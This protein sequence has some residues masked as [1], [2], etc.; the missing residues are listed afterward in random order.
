MIFKLSWRSVRSKYYHYIVYLIGMVFAATIYYSFSAITYDRVLIDSVGQE[1]SLKNAM[2]IGSLLIIVMIA[3]FMIT[4]NRFFF[5]QRTKEIGI[6]QLTGMKNRQIAS[7]LLTE[8]YILGAAALIAGLILGIIFSKL[9]SMILVK[10]MY[11]NVE[12]ILRISVPS[13]METTG[14]FI[15][16]LLIVSI[17]ICFLVYSYQLTSFFKKEERVGI[18]SEKLTKK[19]LVLGITGIGLIVFSYILSFNIWSLPTNSAQLIRL[20]SAPFLLVGLCT[21]GTY[22]IFK[23]T[24][25]IL[26]QFFSSRK[27]Y[28]SNGL[29]MLSAGNTRLHLSK[30]SNTLTAVSIF[31]ACALGIIGGAASFYTLGMESVNSSDPVDFIVSSELFQAAEENAAEQ[32]AALQETRLNFKMTGARYRY[33]YSISRKETLDYE[34]P[35]N[36]ISLSNYQDYQEINPYLQ[37]VALRSENEAV[38]LNGIQNTFSRFIEYDSAVQ[39]ASGRTIMIAGMVSDYLGNSMLRYNK[40]TMVVSDEVYEAIPADVIFELSAFNLEQRE[41]EILPD[42]IMAGIS[43][44]WQHPVYYGTNANDEVYVSQEPIQASKTESVEVNEQEGWRLNYTSRIAAFIHNR[45]ALGVFIYV[46]LFLGVLALIITGSVLMVRQFAEAEREKAT[47]SLLRKLGISEKQL[48]RLIYRQNI[49]VFLLPIL[50]GLLHAGFA[51]RLYSQLVPS[52]GYWLVYLSCGLLII[53]YAVYFLVTSS[54]YCWIAG[55]SNK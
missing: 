33:S 52:S 17:H 8:L 38:I 25:H 43:K 32:G 29:T 47:F 5:F 2:G 1:V 12:S 15:W 37:T 34:G 20:L 11:L 44:E 3:C 4:V 26:I 16:L 23:Y 6:Y 30:G 19:Q 18:Q 42:Q 13:V 27:G 14:I 9:F 36:V 39:L 21:I 49:V 53:I 50:L 51:I 46:M 48:R 41:G 28:Y 45:K 24:I 7:L 35:I 10:I 54:V 40:P 55:E 22:L 31:I